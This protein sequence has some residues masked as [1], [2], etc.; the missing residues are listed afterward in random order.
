MGGRIRGSGC[1]AFNVKWAW[2]VGVLSLA[3]LAWIVGPSG[4]AFPT[5]APLKSTAADEVH[6]DLLLRPMVHPLGESCSTTALCPNAVL[7][8][9][10]MS[11]LVKSS[12]SNG[13]GQSIV[14]VDAC[15]DSGIATDLAK[16]D[17]VNHLAAPKLTV[18]R[19]QGTPCSNSLWSLETS[20]DVE[21]AHVVAPGAA[22]NLV[23]AAHSTFAALYAGWNYSLVHHLGKQVS[24]SWGG[25]G[26]CGP[27]PKALL[28]SAATAQ[29]T[30]LASA[31]DTSAWGSGTSQT[32]QAP[33][34]CAPV[35]AVG[36]T[37]LNVNASGGYQSEAAW[38]GS[39]G[40]YVAS[41]HEPSYE[42]TAALSDSYSELA[43][44]D[45]AAVADPSTGVWVYNGHAGGWQTVGGTS[46]AC[47]M[48][49]GFVADANSWRASNS[50]SSLGNFN[51]YLYLHVYGISG[52][53]SNYSAEI[54]DVSSGSN[55]WA[56]GTG[57]DAAT[58]I[59]SFNGYPL[60]SQL[61][62]DSSA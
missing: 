25:N 43:K 40:G 21:W 45:V 42:T 55:G 46:V 30:V 23:V 54:H 15:G 14:I 62:T 18:Y 9:Y 61:G 36:G 3:S 59:G 52:A 17:S 56:A 34:D 10:N 37:T 5:P 58:G 44:P 7:S 32:S 48:W 41:T 51:A 6:P 35:L 53:S 49:A 20:L 26:G 24:N 8:A 31:G 19:P 27:T 11:A 4:L 29:V 39:G 2:V 13:T 47:P 50:F 28:A 33:A 60:A 1:G 12:T 22:I 57:W 16:F 38:S